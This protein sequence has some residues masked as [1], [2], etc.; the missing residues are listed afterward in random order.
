MAHAST[1]LILVGVLLVAASHTAS[2]ASH[3]H[4]HFKIPDVEMIKNQLINS[5]SGM[6][7]EE[8]ELFAKE[9]REEM[10][11][12]VHATHAHDTKYGQISALKSPLPP[13]K[14]PIAHVPKD[15]SG[16]HTLTIRRAFNKVD[17]DH[18]GFITRNESLE[19]L[20]RRRAAVT[21]AVVSEYV[22]RQ[23][24]ANIIPP[25]YF[26]IPKKHFD[27]GVNA[28]YHDQL[29]LVDQARGKLKELEESKPEASNWTKMEREQYERLKQGI[30]MF[31]EI[32]NL[33]NRI[34]ELEESGQGDSDLAHQMR[35]NLTRRQKTLHPYG[36]M[37]ATPPSR[38]RDLRIKRFQAH[39]HHSG[40]KEDD[41]GSHEVVELR[42]PRE[43][44]NLELIL[45]QTKQR[46]QDVIDKH[47]DFFRLQDVNGD[48][49]I[50]FKE[51]YW[52]MKR[53]L[54]RDHDESLNLHRQRWKNKPD[55]GHHTADGFWIPPAKQEDEQ[56]R[57]MREQQ[58]KER[59]KVLVQWEEEL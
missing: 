45:Q 16:A 32:N 5:G 6:R 33:P 1:L 48:G 56:T 47:G 22:R 58:E 21:R 55:A 10:I 40:D 14:D 31:E 2:A 42:E 3:G 9:K 46:I 36:E 12:H 39:H 24:L 15:L 34:K 43:S 54:M 23:D 41:D 50:D 20:Y 28:T 7:G 52:R 11:K 29:R 51:F 8:L 18:D 37:E 35:R 13:P 57:F 19:S 30:K 4:D 25:Q 59:E 44:D 49:K 53:Q 26:Y 38:E 17:T 27:A